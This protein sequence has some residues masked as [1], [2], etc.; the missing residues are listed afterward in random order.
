MFVD[1][2]YTVNYSCLW[3]HMLKNQCAISTA[4]NMMCVCA[5]VYVCVDVSKELLHVNTHPHIVDASHIEDV[6][7]LKYSEKWSLHRHL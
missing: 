6:L 4:H 2:I 1:N 3:C 5:C 7:H